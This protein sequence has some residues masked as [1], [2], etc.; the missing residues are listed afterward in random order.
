MDNDHYELG[1]NH[2]FSDEKPM[3]GFLM[4]QRPHS[5]TIG[6]LAG[7]AMNVMSMQGGSDE[8]AAYLLGKLAM[9]YNITADAIDDHV[10]D[11]IFKTEGGFTG[12]LR[13]EFDEGFSDKLKELT[14]DEEY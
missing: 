14:K 8:L 1:K 10:I 13:S 12:E 7:Y 9:Q 11:A 6:Y 5:Y 2:G 3:S 4:S